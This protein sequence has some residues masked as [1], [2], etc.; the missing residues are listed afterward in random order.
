[1]HPRCFLREPYRFFEMTPGQIAVLGVMVQ[2]RAELEVS[3]G[4]YPLWRLELEHSLETVHTQ[5]DFWRA[6]RAKMLG[7]TKK[8]EVPGLRGLGSS[9]HFDDNNNKNKPRPERSSRRD[10]SSENSKGRFFKPPVPVTKPRTCFSYDGPHLRSPLH[11]VPE[12]TLRSCLYHAWHKK[13]LGMGRYYHPLTDPHIQ[14]TSFP[15]L[16]CT[17]DP[18]HESLK[19]LYIMFKKKSP[20]VLS[21]PKIHYIDA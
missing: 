21:F 9:R 19:L 16:Y 15:L 1:M 17:K 14:L 6:G 8:G 20:H 10:V 7:E 2:D 3:S 5:A 11:K 4:F 12:S 18:Q 13:E